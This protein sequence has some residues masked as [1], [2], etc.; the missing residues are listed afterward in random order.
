[1]AKPINPRIVVKFLDGDTGKANQ[2]K[3]LLV[4]KQMI[5]RDSNGAV[6]VDNIITDSGGST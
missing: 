3:G 2:L 1:M 5:R 4:A 6:V